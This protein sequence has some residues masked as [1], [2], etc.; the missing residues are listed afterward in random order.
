MKNT[1]IFGTAF[2]AGIAVVGGSF[3]FMGNGEVK[4]AIEANDYAAFVES[5]PEMMLERI[6]SEEA[7]NEF[8]ERKTQMEAAHEAMKIA[9]TNAVANN[10]FVAFEAAHE[11]MQAQLEALRPDDV[12]ARQRRAERTDEE[13]QTHFDELVEYYEA[14]GE[15]PER[16][17]K[18]GKRGGE[19]MWMRGEAFELGQGKRWAHR[20]NGDSEGF[21]PRW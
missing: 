5:A 14:N 7:F 18:K 15:L 20:E 16:Q 4:D 12:E 11:A 9:T 3:A 17:M 21:G 13:Q 1:L 10:D 6:D 2:I 19:G 8:T